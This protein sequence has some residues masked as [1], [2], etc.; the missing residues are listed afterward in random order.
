M[1]ERT[2]NVYVKKEPRRVTLQTYLN[3]L[4]HASKKSAI[5]R[6]S[7][8][9]NGA[10]EHNISFQD[11]Q[12]SWNKQNGKCYYSNIPMQYNKNEWKVSLERLDP[13][14]GYV[15]DNVVLCCLELN[16]RSQWSNSKLD[17]MLNIIIQS[18]D[19]VNTDFQA[20]LSRKKHDKLERFV[21]NN[22]ELLYK[23][24][25]CNITKPST[26]Y[27]K[28][29]DFCK[30]CIYKRNKTK[31]TT[32]KGHI[33]LLCQSSYTAAQK[34]HTSNDNFA[35]SQYDIDYEFL[36]DLYNKQNGLCSYSGLPLKFGTYTETNWVASIER[37]DVSKGY[38]KHNVCLICV[39]FNG[40][41]HSI[42]TGSDYGCA[43]W[44]P[45]KFQYFLA[46]VQHKKGLITDKELQAVID[47]Q[48]QF[49]EKEGNTRIS[50]LPQNNG[51]KQ[52]T[53]KEIKDAIQHKKR[54][55]KNVHE[56]YGHIYIV[57]S[58]SGKQFIGQSKLLYH[59]DPTTIFWHAR[60][61]GYTSLI[62]EVDEYGKDNMTIQPIATCRMDKL[63][64]YQ[65]HFIKEF[66]TYEPNGL[67][68]KKKVRDDV[69][70]NISKGRI[71]NVVRQDADGQQLPKYVKFIDWKDRRGYAIVSH[72]KCK[73]KYFVS[74]KK[75]L[76][77]LKEQC[78][79]FLNHIA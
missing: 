33:Q 59:K 52:V 28:I 45:L 74:N 24:T 49:K 46:H 68:H 5:K 60:K 10:G 22:G 31:R 6:E 19:K 1:N 42:T 26:E 66:N 21:N 58:P 75:P 27:R 44:T 12:D 15:K 54:Q 37:L 14:C 41:D 29:G 8:G 64:E 43:G 47:V 62:K 20:T 50:K 63:D 61:K 18:I 3:Q 73:L 16:T 7:K 30:E 4:Y 11:L 40:P 77:T 65:E 2:E 69:K 71:D 13:S 67:N 25:S 34:R 78:I 32:P 51:L 9:R 38:T 35:R 53:V 36:V 23:C 17:E 76:Q 70:E 56:H 79:T 57:T 39:E 55:Y 48:Q 72:P